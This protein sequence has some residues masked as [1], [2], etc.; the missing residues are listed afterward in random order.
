MF[1]NAVFHGIGAAGILGH[2]AADR[3]RVK[4]L[5]VGRKEKIKPGKFPVKVVQNDADFGGHRKI[6]DIDFYNFVHARRT[7]HN[8]AVDRHRTAADITAGPSRCHRN[9]LGRCQLHN[10]RDLFDGRRKNHHIRFTLP[11]GG[12]VEGI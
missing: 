11:T 9:F 3:R 6:I 12:A 1:K 10:L 2:A 7:Q 4:T 5:R 8:A